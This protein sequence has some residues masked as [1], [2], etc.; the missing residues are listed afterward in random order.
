M[1]DATGDAVLVFKNAIK[2][3]LKA[4]GSLTIPASAVITGGTVPSRVRRIHLPI[5][6][7]TLGSTP[8]TAAAVGTYN[9]LSFDA[10]AET[11]HRNFRVPDDWDGASNLSLK[12][13]FVNE[14]GTAITDGQTVIWLTSLRSKADEEVAD[15]GTA[16][17]GS[18]THTQSGAGTDKEFNLVT[19]AIDYDDSDQPVAAG[20]T[21][22]LQLSR[23]F[24]NDTYA[25]DATLVDAWVEYSSTVLAAE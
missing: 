25:A 7:W 13:R 6:E 16:A 21:V 3:R 11:L 20:D 9:G 19:V 8:P 4:N 12:L 24:T 17:A 2:V 22:G 1:D 5:E 15:A 23:D 18:G 10:D 14:A